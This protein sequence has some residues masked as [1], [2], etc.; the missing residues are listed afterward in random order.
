[1]L[2]TEYAEEGCQGQGREEG[3]KGIN[4]FM[5]SRAGGWHDRHPVGLSLALAVFVLA[6]SRTHAA[7]VQVPFLHKHAT[8]AQRL[9]SIA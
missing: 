3:A 6:P 8:A 5:A 9:I 4:S 2:P 7:L 1:M